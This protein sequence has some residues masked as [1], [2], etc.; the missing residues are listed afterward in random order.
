MAAPSNCCTRVA[1]APRTH[2]ACLTP[3][4][5]CARAAPLGRAAKLASKGMMAYGIAEK[6]KAKYKE[7]KQ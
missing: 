5:C 6:S 1:L 4:D 7:G 3:P 2:A